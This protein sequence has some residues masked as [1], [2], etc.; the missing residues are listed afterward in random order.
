MTTFG[1]PQGPVYP[2]GLITVANAGTP[3][4]LS[5][6]VGTNSSFG[7]PSGGVSPLTAAGSPAP[8]VCNKLIITPIGTAGKYIYLIYKGQA[9][10]A[11][12]GTSVI[13]AVPVGQTFVLE[14]PPHAGNPLALDRLQLDTDT[15][16]T[17]AFV[18]AIMG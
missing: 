6:R 13:C 12:N 10:G 17:A 9:A 3:V 16:G 1:N 5:Q 18:T 7:T 14:M 4:D 2:L 8:L 15:N 11:G